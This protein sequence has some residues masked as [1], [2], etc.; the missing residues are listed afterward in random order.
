MIGW[1]F[2]SWAAAA[3]A[4]GPISLAPQTA[5]ADDLRAHATLGGAHAVGAPQYREFGVGGA[6]SASLELP[7]GAAFGLEGKLGGIVLA[8]GAPPRDPSVAKRSAGTALL[9]TIGLRARPFTAVA[10]PWA[11][12]GLGGAQTGN[13]TRFA[14]D[15]A[16]GWDFR[17]T[18]EGRIDIGPFVGF[19]D[20]VQA[21]DALR[22]NDAY[23]V[24]LGVHVALGV[25]PKPKPSS[26]RD[27]DG[28][29]DAADA[30]PDVPGIA[31]SDPKTNGCPR[32]DRDHDAIYDDEDAC[33]DVPGI[34]TAD[35][36]TNGC[37]RGDRDRDMIT[38]DED[39]CPDVAGITTGDPKTNGC[40]RADRDQDGVVDEDDACPDV[41]GV[42]S[43]DPK[44]NG[45]PPATERVRVEQD[46]I[47]FDDVI[48]YDLDS[49]RVK[50]A[51]WGIIQKLAEFINATP[52]IHEVS[53]EGHADATGTAEHNLRLSRERAE[54][55][56]RLLV[57][58][59]VDA[60]RIKAEAYGRSHLKVQTTHAEAQNRRVELWITRT[61]SGEV[62]PGSPAPAPA[63]A[64]SAPPEG[65]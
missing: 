11:S 57:K 12:V 9:G 2:T 3:L 41:P 13:R 26:D 32:A 56:K 14:L 17:A 7:F 64:P 38:D 4:F 58:F 47:L 29:F 49:P 36:K 28:I 16:I 53:I 37:P 30:C 52:E 51:S 5:R 23:V 42:P 25:K 43:S 55:V 59:G 33:P 31:T 39:A 6:A 34:R 8:D 50:H 46:R 44:T 48:L 27:K 40:P 35:P 65:R 19:N 18:R 15:A 62:S 54:N 63:P 24:S 20:I 10:G 60:D 45:C 21:D 1:R 22:P 61:R